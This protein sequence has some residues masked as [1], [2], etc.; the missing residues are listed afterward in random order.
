[1][2][3]NISLFEGLNHKAFTVCRSLW[4]DVLGDKDRASYSKIKNVRE[5]S[6]N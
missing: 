6:S 1:M 3:E 4:V 2:D 5:F